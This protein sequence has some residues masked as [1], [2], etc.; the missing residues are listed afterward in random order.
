MISGSPRPKLIPGTHLKVKRINA[1]NIGLYKP[2]KGGSSQKKI[3]YIIRGE[4]VGNWAGGRNGPTTPLGWFGNLQSNL[5][6]FLA[7]EVLGKCLN[8]QGI[9]KNGWTLRLCPEWLPVFNSKYSYWRS[10][11]EA[12]L[13]MNPSAASS[14]TSN[15]QHQVLLLK[16]HGRTH[17]GNEPFGCPQCDFEISPSSALIEEAW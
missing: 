16:K 17:T 8:Q 15:F 3:H 1:K 9:P 14:V 13:G 6:P 5:K 12:S 11:I 2:I 7:S 10:M 4:K